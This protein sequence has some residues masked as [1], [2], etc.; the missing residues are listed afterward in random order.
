M[1]RQFF[2]APVVLPMYNAR[3]QQKFVVGAASHKVAGMVASI[4]AHARRAVIVS[5]PVVTASARRVY[6]NGFTCHDGRLACVYLPSISVRGLNRVFSGFSYLWF[7]MRRIR[8]DDAVVFYN[9][10]PEYIPVAALLRWRLGRARVILDIEDGPREDQKDLRGI[11]G[12]WSWRILKRLCSERAIVVSRQV[13]SALQIDDACVVNGVCSDVAPR[14]RAFGSP[15][16]ILYG[17]SIEPATGLDLFTGAVH[18]FAR[19]YPELAPNV[20]FVVTG[21]GGTA[22]LSELARDVSK[23]GV[24]VDV[25]QDLGPAEYK[26]ILAQAD[27]GLSLKMPGTD[28]V[29]TTFPSKVVEL[30]S[31]GLLV[32][33]TNVSDIAQLFDDATAVV[34]RVAKPDELAAR[35]AAIAREPEQYR[36]IAEAG[37]RAIETQCGR[38]EVGARLIEFLRGARSAGG[39]RA[40]ITS[41]RVARLLGPLRFPLANT[42]IG[43][44][45]AT[46]MF[47][48]K[49]ALLRLL[50]FELAPGCRIAGGVKF[51][52][53]GQVEIGRDTWIGLDCTFIVAPDAPVKIGAR[54]DIAPQTIF[55]TGSHLIG[56]GRRRAGAGYS[57]AIGVGDG[58]WVGTRCTLLA[59]VTIGAGSIVAGGATVIPGDYPPD[60][61]LAGCPAVVK[62]EL[63]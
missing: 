21:F 5:S 25:M 11:V 3:Q 45:P 57:K 41:N 7:A 49:R 48:V 62:R 22:Q 20:R 42:V 10:F 54:C 46:R 53:K 32:A 8:R 39:T 36:R 35:I 31:H 2:F 43:A 24:R 23:L 15:V 6:F 1:A 9:Y 63:K 30:A 29:A 12:R 38:R 26:E 44:L 55:H 60:V 58:S 4:R 56:D 18:R 28:L 51:F 17:G 33:T 34:L 47:S 61:L 19:Q 40:E 59:G 50:G 13:A 52:G 16:L 27:V 14:D 37:Q